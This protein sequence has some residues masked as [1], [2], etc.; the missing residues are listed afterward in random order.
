[1]SRLDELI[2]A[3]CP[4]GV[5]YKSIGQICQS[6]K[7]E[8]IKQDLLIDNGA[9][10]VINSGRGYYG[11]LDRYNNDGNAITIASRGEYAG[12]ILYH[13]TCFMA[14]GLCYPY[15]SINENLYLTKFIFYALKNQ[16]VYIR[17][18][19]VAEGSI[20]ALNK[21]DI[22]KFSIPVPPLSIQREI[23]RLL[24]CFTELT[25]NLTTE[26]AARQKQY[27]YYRDYL[28]DEL[29][30]APKVKLKDIATN[31]FR[32][33]GIKRDEVTDE[34]IPCVR[35]GEIYTKYNTWFE[36]CISHTDLKYV[37]SPKF[38]GHG[39]ILFAITG[40]SVEDISKSIAYLGN[41]QCLAGGD[42]VVMQHEQEPRYLAHALSTTTARLQKGKGKVKSKVVHSSIPSI[43]SIE[44]PLPSIERQKD[45]AD[46]LDNFEILCNKNGLVD[47]INARGKQYEYYRGKLLSFLQKKVDI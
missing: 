1:M 32:G 44:I 26:L 14:G 27:E 9:Y 22:E 17:H 39:D 28:I 20:P 7:K 8:T 23:V 16:E 11:Y 41:N 29:W 21:Q 35:Y 6:L 3:L 19:L 37:S 38:F 15:R 30:D 13:A 47:E 36:N 45:I 43:E 34:G 5:E 42:I 31:M 25:N 40:E 46:I 2:T 12:W 4:D 10:P 33:A 24:D 18:V